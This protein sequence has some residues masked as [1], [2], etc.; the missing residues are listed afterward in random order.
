MANST[1]FNGA[2][3]H[4]KM[5]NGH[6]KSTRVPADSR[7]AKSKKSRPPLGAAQ[8]GGVGPIGKQVR[9]PRGVR[10]ERRFTSP[11]VDPLAAVV[12]ERRA[13]TITNPDGSMVFK[14]EG[15]EVPASWSQLATDILISKYFRKAGL[16][17]DKDTGELKAPYWC[18][19]RYESSASKASA[20]ALLAK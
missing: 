6:D 20:S 17:G 19:S 2:G 15:A 9:A 14:M 16:Y 10:V 4:L 8:G 1:D 18:T 5:R 3:T 7:S 12:Y 11:A 13:S